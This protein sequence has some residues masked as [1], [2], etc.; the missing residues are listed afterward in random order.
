M[1]IKKRLIG[2]F[3]GVIEY[4]LPCF[5]L[6]LFYILYFSKFKIQTEI[7]QIGRQYF[8]QLKSLRKSNHP[9]LDCEGV[10][11]WKAGVDPAVD[12]LEV[13]TIVVV[14]DG[15]VV[16]AVE[17]VVATTVVVSGVV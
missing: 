8:Q 5:A 7:K 9:E 10:E 4:C 16:V 15:A 13:D 1:S 3:W 12:A 2:Q 11:V 6:T 17:A 14:V